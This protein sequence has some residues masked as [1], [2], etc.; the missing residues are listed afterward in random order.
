[1]LSK[2]RIA[3]IPLFYAAIDTRQAKDHGRLSSTASDPE[4]HESRK[5]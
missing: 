3:E 5:S 2:T 4:A 1:M